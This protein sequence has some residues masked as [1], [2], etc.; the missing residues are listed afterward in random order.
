MEQWQCPG[1]CNLKSLDVYIFNMKISLNIW[2]VGLKVYLEKDVSIFF[3][4][5]PPQP[6]LA[7]VK[8]IFFCAIT[9]ASH[10]PGCPS[11]FLPVHALESLGYPEYKPL[12]LVV[13]VPLLREE[14]LGIRWN[15]FCFPGSSL[16]HLGDS[17][18]PFT[19]GSE[20]DFWT[21]PLSSHGKN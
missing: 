1:H 7:L 18:I 6:S 19:A 10:S 9:A 15:P 4:G 16:C 17:A 21:F 13:E 8:Y 14:L 2:K 20:W 12:I 3:T 5:V 11:W